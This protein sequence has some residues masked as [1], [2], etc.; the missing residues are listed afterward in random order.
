MVTAVVAVATTTVAVTMAA[1][2]AVTTAA[3]A[4]GKKIP[5]ATAEGFF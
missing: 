5:S 2:M 3:V 4:E 1:A